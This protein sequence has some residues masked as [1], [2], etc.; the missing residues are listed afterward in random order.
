MSSVN[1]VKAAFEP[2]REI[3][4]GDVPA[5]YTPTNALSTFYL[6]VLH[7]IRIL[8]IVNT[9]NVNVYMSYG[10]HNLNPALLINQ[11]YIP[12]G[13]CVYDFGTNMSESAG[14]FELPVNTSFFV[15]YDTT[16]PYGAPTSG[17]VTITVIYASVT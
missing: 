3:L 16:P 2:L 17:K 8:K 9:S 13:A 14:L 10:Q 6:P 4:F 1:A 11:D 12:A 7:P 15:K 5:T